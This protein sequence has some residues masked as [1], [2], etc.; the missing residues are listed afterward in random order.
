MEWLTAQH[1]NFEDLRPWLAYKRVLEKLQSDR[2]CHHLTE[3]VADWMTACES[4]R[5]QVLAVCEPV[6][7]IIASAKGPWLNARLMKYLE[8]FP[9]SDVELTKHWDNSKQLSEILATLEASDSSPSTREHSQAHPFQHEEHHEG[10]NA[11]PGGPG[12]AGVHQ[13]PQEQ[14]EHEPW[15]VP[16]RSASSQSAAS[17]TPPPVIQWSNEHKSWIDTALGTPGAANKLEDLLQGVSEGNANLMLGI[18]CIHR[19]TTCIA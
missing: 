7:R 17:H 11:M 3:A 15:P 9:P 13:H 18:A 8:P 2:N 5:M 6:M 4:V 1:A 19:M 10:A 16:E 14:E 12:P